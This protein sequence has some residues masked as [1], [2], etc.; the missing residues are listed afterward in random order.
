MDARRCKPVIIAGDFNAWAE[1]WGSRLTNERGQILLEEFAV[2]DVLLANIG[3]TYTFRGQGRGSVI[4]LTFISPELS[5]NLRW[6]VSE[7]YTGSDHQALYFETA[8]VSRNCTRTRIPRKRGWIAKAVDVEVIA[9]M[10]SDVRLPP[11]RAESTSKFVVTKLKLACDASMPQ[12][13]INERRKAAYWWNNTIKEQR[14]LCFHARRM[15]QRTYGTPRHEEEVKIYKEARR[16]LRNEIRKSKN[17]SFKN[18]CEEADTNPW[19]SA[20]RLVMAKLGNKPP[21][22][23]NP[24]ILKSIIQE[25]FPLQSPE[26]TINTNIEE[27]PIPEVTEEEILASCRWVGANKAAGPDEIPNNALKAAINCNPLMFAKLMQ[28]CLEEGT[29]PQIWKRQKLVLLPKPGKT[30]GEASA[31]RPICLLDTIGKIL[32][33]VI[34][35]RLVNVT[36][37]S[38]GLSGNQLGFRKKRSTLDA[39][40]AIVATA[41]DAISGKQWKRGSMKYCAFIT[42]DIRNAFNTANW[43]FIMKALMEM[44][45]PAYLLRIIG[46]YLKDRVLLYDTEDGTKEYKVTGGV[47]QGSVLGPTLW[48]VMYD[49]VLRVNLPQEAKIIGF[50]D[51]IV[52][53][54]SAKH[55]EEIECMARESVD[56]VRKWIEGAGLSL[57]EHKT[58]V[59]LISGRKVKEKIK[60]K[61][62]NLVVESKDSLKYLGVMID[63][64]INFKEHIKY[65]CKKASIAHRSL[66]RMMRNIGG[67]RSS[68]RKLLASVVNSTLLYG[69]QIWA[70][71]L[72]VQATRRR[73]LSIHRLSALRVASAYRTVSYD[74]VCIISQMMPIDILA[75]EARRIFEAKIS[76]EL[77][78]D[79]RKLERSTSLSLWQQRWNSSGKGR[80]T[81]KLI[82]NISSWLN[83]KQGEINFYMTQ[84]LSGHGCY[85]KYLYR[86]KRDDSPICPVCI[87][88]EEDVE[89]VMFC[90]PRFDEDRRELFEASDV[91][92]S[93]DNVITEMIKSEEVW[94]AM[95]LLAKRVNEKLREI[96]LFR[97]ST[98]RRYQQR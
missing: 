47:P 98:D 53:T 83:R 30:P 96:E 56:S 87:G 16:Q 24:V 90:C 10:L 50:A 28:V 97:R 72:K 68:S 34:Q 13:T 8:C 25:L 22:E 59:I 40:Q 81:H 35:N 38:N 26:W 80:W 2:L 85:R 11:D 49:G 19:G 57:A 39:I 52:I 63:G 78:N 27:Q 18:L 42:L 75:D 58:E 65:A 93:T 51:D 44:N 61:V 36:E 32:E 88:V 74:A 79:R 54:V 12:R 48:N 4:D 86:F 55:L 3:D 29:F 37:S 89:H 21:M 66:S 33:R 71:A 15:S 14:A 62:G 84:F 20:Y 77:N 9:H 17:K 45:T 82:P 70:N 60:V 23:N 64:K 67:P 6:T 95:S 94:N 41:K 76:G 73:M 43:G 5:R 92:I 31:Y 69:A 7:E 91:L 46:D 1:E